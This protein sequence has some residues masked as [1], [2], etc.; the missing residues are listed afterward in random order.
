MNLFNRKIKMEHSLSIPVVDMTDNRYSV[1]GYF[2]NYSREQCKN[3]DCDC[4]I[5]TKTDV[6]Q[7]IFK[8]IY[9]KIK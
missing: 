1:I 9:E 6:V 2:C 7:E 8:K 5:F 3:L 4:C